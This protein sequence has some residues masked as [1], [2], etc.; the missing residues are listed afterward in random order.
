[1]GGPEMGKPESEEVKQ[2]LDGEKRERPSFCCWRD[3]ARAPDWMT[4]AEQLQGPE[5]QRR[6]REQ[7]QAEARARAGEEVQRARRA[8]PTL[9]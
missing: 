7:E 3:P 6:W 1:M 4:A 9:A 5:E 8:P 2:G